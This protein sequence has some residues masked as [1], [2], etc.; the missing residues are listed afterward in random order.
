MQSGKN[1]LYGNGLNICVSR[2]RLI[3][4]L[5]A[6]ALLESRQICNE[7]SL[8]TLNHQENQCASILGNVDGVE[9]SFEMIGAGWRSHR[10][11]RIHQ[12]SYVAIR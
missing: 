7:P 4:Q 11:V 10:P 1:V 3:A 2:D 8:H 5:A 12:Q 6:E 9:L